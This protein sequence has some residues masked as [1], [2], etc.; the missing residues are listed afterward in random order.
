M[1]KIVAAI[2]LAY[3]MLTY[4]ADAQ[5]VSRKAKDSVSDA[6]TKIITWTSTPSH[7]TGFQIS[8]HRVSGAATAG[9]IL[10][11]T[12]IDT[13]LDVWQTVATH[14][15]TDLVDQ[16]FLDAIAVQSG[17]GYRYSVTGSGTEKLY[18]YA[19]YLRR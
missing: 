8:V 2:I 14:T 7:I 19:A 13:T 11:Q 16:G 3:T 9:T 10:L 1:K 15:L 12:R 4:T 18:L 5:F 17:N 6:G